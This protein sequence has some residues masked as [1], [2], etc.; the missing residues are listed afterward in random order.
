MSVFASRIGTGRVKV[1]ESYLGCNI[2]V[3]ALVSRRNH[4]EAGGCGSDNQWTCVH[5]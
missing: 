4:P 1:G 2:H 3:N 5:V